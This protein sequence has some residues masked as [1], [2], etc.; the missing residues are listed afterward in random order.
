MV[1]WWGDLEAGQRVLVTAERIDLDLEQ[2]R[3]TSNKVEPIERSVLSE[4]I[5]RMGIIDGLFVT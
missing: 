3:R 1:W 4:D 5:Q 2:P